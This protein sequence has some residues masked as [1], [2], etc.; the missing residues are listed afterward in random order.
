MNLDNR[1][2]R[3]SILI[4]PLEPQDFEDLWRILKPSFRAGDTYTI[5]PKVTQSDALH[6]WT[7]SDKTIFLAE[8]SGVP[9][10]TYYIRTN[11][12]G[13][14]D[15]ICNCGFVTYPQARGQGIAT[16]MLEHALEKAREIGFF[17]MQFNFVVETNIRA[18][19][20]WLRFGFEIIGR[21]PKAF[22]HPQYGSTDALIMYKIL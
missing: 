16:A 12:G 14:G 1:D 21:L 18:I 15:H 9:L 17:A 20:I 22:R 8:V 13:N 5:D 2:L 7:E 11:Q 4:R 19:E 10:G 6:Y 3:T